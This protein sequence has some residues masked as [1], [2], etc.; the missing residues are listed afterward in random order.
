MNAI[1]YNNVV[2]CMKA[3]KVCKL[4]GIRLTTNTQIVQ[5]AKNAGFDALFIEMEH[6]SLS[7]AETSNLCM[8][9]LQTG[10]TPLV[11]VPYQCGNG[12]VQRVLDGGAMGVIFPHIHNAGKCPLAMIFSC[13]EVV[14]G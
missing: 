7:L 10:I 11:R 12:F 13:H 14:R 8:A 3:G 4:F 2:A 9:G 6:S 5:L 1:A